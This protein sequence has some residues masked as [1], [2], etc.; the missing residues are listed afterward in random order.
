MELFAV[1][2]GDDGKIICRT[3]CIEVAE[4]EAILLSQTNSI[5]NARVMRSGG[6]VIR[7]YENGELVGYLDSNEKWVRIRGIAVDGVMVVPF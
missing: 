6:Q 7:R 2:A 4:R 5:S 3:D 1:N